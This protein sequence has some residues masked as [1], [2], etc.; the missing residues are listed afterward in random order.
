L[1]PPCDNFRDGRTDGQS[2]ELGAPMT[3]NGRN[4]NALILRL[5]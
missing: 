3:V 5:A 1:S 2:M 4:A